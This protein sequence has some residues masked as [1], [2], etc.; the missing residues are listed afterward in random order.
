LTK[1][2]FDHNPKNEFYVEESF[3]LDWMYPHL[4]PYGV[5]MKINRQPLA[6]LP[7]DVLQ[8]DHLF[9]KQYSKRMTGDIIDY[10]T[11]IKQ[12]TEWIEKTYL[13]H[14]FNGFT[15]DRKF[16]HDD[17]AQ[18]AFSKLRSSIGGIYAWR[19]GQPPGSPYR[20][21]SDAE[22]RNVLREA[23]FTFRQAFAFCPY[24]PEAVFRYVQ[25]LVQLGRAED[26][27][28]IAETCLK[29]DPYNGQV[30]AL[31]SNL[32]TIKNTQ[33]AMMQGQPRGEQA[34]EEQARNNGS[35]PQ[36]SIELARVYLQNKETDKAAQAL[37]SLLSRD[38][39]PATVVIEAAQLYS[40]LGNWSKLETA[41]EKLVK[42]SP[43]SPEAWYD[44]AA[45][46]A[47]FG[48]NSEALPALTQALQLSAK[49]LKAN[50]KARDLVADARKDERFKAL[51]QNPEFQK[52]V[53]GM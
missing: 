50:P 38:G 49:R 29:L 37:D 42:V 22:Y 41:L 19:L 15:G 39:L 30:I 23:E 18:K 5:I 40:S 36:A 14:D 20:P 43:D 45:L 46:K 32:Q 25:L 16:I 27:L 28:L 47:N 6:S 34:L 3:P 31:V 7:D 52:L 12:I 2:M 11:P 8:R 24:S 10:D 21:K 9:W 44:L 53:P 48:K 51:R 1:V 17:D 33:G 13:R 35:N 26:A 4:T